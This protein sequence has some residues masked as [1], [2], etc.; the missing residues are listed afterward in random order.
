MKCL[1]NYGYTTD[2]P[3]TEEEEEH[4]RATTTTPSPLRDQEALWLN[5]KQLSRSGG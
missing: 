2:R 3:T 4:S 5:I 1:L